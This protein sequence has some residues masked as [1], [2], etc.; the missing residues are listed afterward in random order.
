MRN[1]VYFVAVTLDGFIASPDGGV[2]FFD[3]E[4]D[5]MAAHIEHYPE[6]LPVHVR[7]ALGVEDR[8]S[9]RFDTMLMGRGTAQPGLDVGIAS[10]YPHLRQYVFSRTLPDSEDPTITVVRDNPLALARSLREEDGLDIWL[11]GGGDL[12]G[13]LLPVVDELFLKIHPVVLGSGITQ[14]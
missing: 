2:D 7:A 9:Q 14:A 11:A 4:G 13:Q 5:H 1:L 8:P 10:P 12:A 3:Y 6:T